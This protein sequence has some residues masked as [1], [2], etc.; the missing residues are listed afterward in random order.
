MHRSHGSQIGFAPPAAPLRRR[1]GALAGL[2]A[3]GLLLLPAAAVAAE[4]KVSITLTGGKV[5]EGTLVAESPDALTVR[6]AS[7]ATLVVPREK[8]GEVTTH[9]AATDE[10][11]RRE[12]QMPPRD[13]QALYALSRWCDAQSM[14]DE[15]ARLLWQT[16][17]VDAN[18][19]DARGRLGFRLHGDVWLTEADYR[20]AQSE[21]R[22]GGDTWL[23]R[24]EWDAQIAQKYAPEPLA[25]AEAMLAAVTKPAGGAEA[26]KALASFRELPQELC[27]WSLIRATESL[28]ARERQFAVR[29][30]G[31]LGDRAQA[32]LLA[33]L[34]VT[35]GKR[36]VRD[37]ALRVLKEWGSPDTALSFTPYLS[38]KNASYR[39]NAGRALNQ[40]PDR[41]AVERMIETV[42]MTWAGF[43]RTHFAQLVQRAY[44]K[45]YELVSG[46][47]GLIVQEVADPVVDTFMEGIVLDIDPQRVE[48]EAVTR[49]AALQAATGQRF[50]MN[51][52]QWKNWWQGSA[53]KAQLA[54]AAPRK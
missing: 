6:L 16:L 47:T 38:S 26:K 23:P 49:V 46:G 12:A 36:S 27:L 19:W 37:E 14:P 2:I 7:G 4:P 31:A 30:L 25:T 40:F 50:G 9:P 21:V 45:D 32:S 18:H 29:E 13:A 42:D 39:I 11:A 3:A 43:G 15:A 48:A 52:D 35:D 54:S 20:R 1:Q 8:I 53:G 41:R 51:F 10:L 34:A 5:L 33:H 22:V 44:V 17:E 24:V 28:S